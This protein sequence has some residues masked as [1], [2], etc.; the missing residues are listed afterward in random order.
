MNIKTTSSSVLIIINAN[1]ES[2]Q[3]YRF[4]TTF[5]ALGFCLFLMEHKCECA[6]ICAHITPGDK[7][8]VRFLCM[9]PLLL[10][11]LLFGALPLSLFLFY[12][13][14]VSS[15][16]VLWLNVYFHLHTIFTLTLNLLF[17]SPVLCKSMYIE[18]WHCVSV[19]VYICVC[20]VN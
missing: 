20:A 14:L 8:L 18:Q 9:V 5:P 12:L 19:C 11:L 7:W 4:A 15:H 6:L 17:I 13:L 16:F 1:I 2:I 10:L 3:I